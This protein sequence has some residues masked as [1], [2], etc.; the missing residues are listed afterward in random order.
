MQG[1]GYLLKVVLKILLQLCH[2]V[3]VKNIHFSGCKFHKEQKIYKRIC[4]KP[5]DQLEEI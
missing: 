4:R 1:Y 5:S 2:K 3:L